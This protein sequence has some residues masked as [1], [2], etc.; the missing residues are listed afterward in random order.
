MSVSIAFAQ[1]SMALRDIL[2]NA[3]RLDTGWRETG[4]A[5]RV[6]TLPHGKPDKGSGERLNLGLI[7]AAPNARLRNESVDTPS[8]RVPL[9]FDLR[10]LI[11]VHVLFP[12]HAELLIGAALEALLD[13]PVLT[14]PPVPDEDPLETAIMDVAGPMADN[15]PRLIVEVAEARSFDALR[16]PA[17]LVHVSPV[18]VAPRRRGASLLL[19]P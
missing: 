18:I 3:L 5:P 6:T 12:L 10:Y 2:Q 19:Q 15:R 11:T 9:V 16:V 13:N 1:T 14:G 17:L 7:S 8:G 4:G